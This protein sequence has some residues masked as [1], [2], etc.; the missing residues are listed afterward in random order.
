[1]EFIGAHAQQEHD[2]IVAR[3]GT[4][5][6]LMMRAR[7]RATIAVRDGDHSVARS[8]LDSGIEELRIAMHVLGREADLESSSEY[9]LLR[10]MRDMLMP[11]LP[12]SQRQEIRERLEQAIAHE[13]YELAAILTAELRQLP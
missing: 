5:Q 4:L 8:A 12:A 3:E 10:G 11:Q 9:R 6:L 13:N 2:Q 7:A 1:M